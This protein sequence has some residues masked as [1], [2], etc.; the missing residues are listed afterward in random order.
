MSERL[1]FFAELKRRNVY[2]VAVA[3]VVVAWLLLQAAS[4][5]LP[6]F[7][8]PSW[9]MKF[10]IVV[11][12]LGFPVVLILS[13]AFE[14]TSEGIKLESEIAPNQSITR[15]TGRKI[16]GI[17][18]MLAVFAAGL[19][20]FQIMSPKPS[21]IS[22]KTGPHSSDPPIES[23]SI[24]VLPF[25][26]LSHDPE[27]A[28]FSEGIQD[29]IL[30]RLAKIGDFKVISRTSTE[31]YKSAP[32]NLREIAQQ[33]GVA[34]ILEGSVQKSTDQVRVNVQLIN[35]LTDAHLWAE[36][37]DRKLTDIFAVESEIAKTVAENLQAKL[38]GR[39]EKMLAAR[40]TENLEAHQLYLKGRF[41][42][43]KRT[44]ENLRKAIDYF[45]QAIE[46]DPAYALAY[47]GLADAHAILPIY[48][49]T[50]PNDDVPA[51]LAAARKAVE[52]D[53]SLAEAHTSLANALLF[54]VQLAQAEPEF[55]RAIEL[56][57]N[58]ATAHQWYGECLQGE[59]R[60]AEAVAQLRRAQDL[61]PLSLIINSSYG[62]VLGESGQPE[63]GVAQ[64]HKTLE[65]DPT[66]W[67]TREILGGILEGKGDLKGAAAEYEKSI[68]QNWTANGAAR[69]ASVNARLGKKADVRKTLDDLTTQS[70]QHWVPPY[71]LA[72]IHL[73]LGENEEALRLLEKS[74]DERS[75]FLQGDFGSLKTDKRL[76]P[77]RRD[78]RFKNLERR[79]MTGQPE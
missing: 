24:A 75:I 6:A 31:K 62:C 35:A 52:L 69:L 8:S 50:P 37:Y 38:N 16:V 66:F 22:E 71:A 29:E 48:A 74:L 68:Q 9:V 76:D 56:N 17:T 33:L 36:T 25:E 49:S 73:A 72:V 54:N 26:N 19:M 79:F 64:L 42:W 44:P 34:H 45:Q 2:K 40:P 23:K 32:G 70:R 4:I 78:P 20:I 47:A 65:M 21:A 46:K 60:F 41:F 51:A 12:I 53:D 63:E 67:V 14:L 10:L 13:W 28:Y 58:Y 77:L 3:Y 30:T 15:R 43:N 7:D 11:I 1:S 57:P 5:F 61:D 59:G 18:I 55:R 39:A 27:N